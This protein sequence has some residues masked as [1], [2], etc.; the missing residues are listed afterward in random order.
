M[1]AQTTKTT[2][3]PEIFPAITE[4]NRCRFTSSHGRRC[5]NPLRSSTIGFCIIHERQAQKLN[6][7]EAR[8]ISEELLSGGANLRTLDDVNRVMSKLFLFVSQKRISRHDGALL[9]YICSLLLQTI[10]TNPTQPP[11]RI[12]WDVFPENN[13]P[14]ANQGPEHGRQSAADSANGGPQ[15]ADS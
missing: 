1:P 6:D 2:A 11:I 3:E 14:P 9:A 7:A 13:R 5:A 12:N 10:N 8:A 15:R 4:Q